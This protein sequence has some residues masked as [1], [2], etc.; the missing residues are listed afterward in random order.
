M[1]DVKYVVL[2]D[3]HLGA[4]NSLLTNLNFEKSTETDVTQPSPVLVKLM[5]CLKEIIG[6]NIRPKNRP[7]LV[8]NGDIIELALSTTNDAA[9]AFKR[10]LEL[11]L[12]KRGV[13]LFDTEIIFMAGNHDHN[14]WERARNHHYSK[15]MKNLDPGDFIKNEPHVT[16]LF[17]RGEIIADF[18]QSIIRMQAHL[19]DITVK[20]VY[21]AHA[22]LSEDKNKCVVITHGHYVE[23]MYS[24]MTQLRLMVFPDRPLPQNFATLEEENYAWVDFFWS[25]LGRSGSVG[26]D[27]DLIY[28]KM[29]DPEEVKGLIHNIAKS[30]S[31]EKKNKIA[32]KIE[33][34]LLER[35]LNK[36]LGEMAANERNQPEVVLSDDAMDGLK[37]FIEIYLLAQIKHELNGHV[38]EDMAFI[39]G[40]THKP[41]QKKIQFEGYKNPIKVYNGGGWVVDT[42][43][44]Q[45]LHGGSM[46]LI[47]EHL[48]VVTLQMYREGKMEVTIEDIDTTDETNCPFFDQ[49]KAGVDMSKEPWSGFASTVKDQVAQRHKN[50]AQ[51]A[52][53]NG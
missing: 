30:I 37:K 40:H 39:F 33:E 9:M 17:E 25:T 44:E 45:P 41:F 27:I 11:I 16:S 46:I 6:M 31:L 36:T 4:E 43:Y 12:P 7:T 32:R 23:S 34:K 2:S 5:D 35:I 14:L 51:I 18:I 13:F 20:A 10:F 29:Q 15:Y 50:L 8:L 53:S 19:R 47:D 26:K 3:M 21:P 38:P 1:A 28:A 24:L 52:K 49:I 42:M 48:D 22:L